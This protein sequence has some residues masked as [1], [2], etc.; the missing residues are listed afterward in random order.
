M[1]TLFN[2]Y[3]NITFKQKLLIIANFILFV[4]FISTLIFRNIGFMLFAI[5][6]L[7]FLYYIYLFNKNNKNKYLE[8]LNINNIG[9]IDNN[10]CVKP[11][12]DNPFMN[13]NIF[14]NTNNIKCCNIE[15]V[16]VIND[17]NNYFKTPVYKDV[18][19]IYER[20]FSERQF[21][22]VPA[23]TIPNDQESF[24]KWLYF[25]KPTC[26][27]NNGEQCYNNIM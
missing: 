24:S 17:I 13:P 14:N 3:N 22:S 19:D 7:I 4:A 20:N 15:D 27:E 6:I 9:I 18:T 23:T 1:I 10:Y 16:N 2:S 5:I 21:Y 25:R 12:R 26:K 8:K 11:S